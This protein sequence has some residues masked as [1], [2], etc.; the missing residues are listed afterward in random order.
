MNLEKIFKGGALLFDGGMGTMLQRRGL[1]AGQASDMMNLTHPEVVTGVHREYV[2]AGAQV[3]STNTFQ[4]HSVNAEDAS[5]EDVVQAGVDC[6]RTA[7]AEFIALSVGPLGKILEPCGD[8]PF[9]RARQLFLR[10]IL[11]GKAAG[12][13][14][15]LIETMYDL[16]E[17]RAAVLAAK[18][19]AALPII[20]T[21]TFQ[22]NGRSL[23]GCSPN[24]AVSALQ[25]LGVDALGVNCSA[26]PDQI[27]PVIEIML[28]CS[29]L[30]LLAQPNAGLPVIRDG[31]AVY[32]LSPEQFAEKMAHMANL[33]VAMLGGC[34]GTT[35]E[36]IRALAERLVNTA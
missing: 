25:E 20:C 36:H 28:G 11:A 17:V 8:F 34:C 26:G 35:P 12:A 33:G 13:D 9:E 10:H 15:I 16:S 30:P 32:G 7:G 27:L 5:V 2:Q 18:E 22:E 24:E 3:I 6:A 14:C 19:G 1:P 23:M 29:K 4:A 31:V 21:M